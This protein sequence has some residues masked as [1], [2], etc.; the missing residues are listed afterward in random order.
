MKETIKSLSSM[1]TPWW[2]QDKPTYTIV[3]KINNLNIPTQYLKYLAS[4]YFPNVVMGS[5]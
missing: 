4:N 2:R 3:Y 5:T 1:F